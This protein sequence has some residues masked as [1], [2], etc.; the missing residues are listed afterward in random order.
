M[1]NVYAFFC[2]VQEIIISIIMLVMIAVVLVATFCRYTQVA[3]LNWPDEMT[4][5]L[6][7][8][9]VFIGA[10]AASK[11]NSHFQITAVFDRLPPTG[12]MIMLAVRMVACNCLYIFMIKV[13]IGLIK[14]L[15][16]MEQTSPAMHIPMWIMYLAVPVGL[17]LMMLQGM[18]TDVIKMREIIAEKQHGGAAV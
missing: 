9:M 12:K 7:V 2:R 13:G 17:A 15:F 5:Y 6:M 11:N 16:V 3:V 4:R 8:W 14:K 18:I 10:G 1:K